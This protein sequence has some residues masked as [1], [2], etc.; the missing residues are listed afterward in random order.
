MNKFTF[1]DTMEKALRELQVE[2]VRD[3]LAEYEEHFAFK[4]ADGYSEEEIAAK[5]GGPR[6]LAKQFAAD[7]LPG[8]KRGS[9][10]LTA[11][12]LGFADIFTGSF[13]IALFGFVLVILGT[14]VAS[15]TIGVC[16][17][18]NLSGFGLLPPVPYGCALLFAAAF[19][20]FAILMGVGTVYFYVSTRQLL[21]SYCRWHQNA[22]ASAKGG[23]VYPPLSTHPQMGPRFNRRLRSVTLIA[24]TAFAVAFVLAYVVSAIVAGGFGFWHIWGWFVQ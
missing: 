8:R 1:M 23:A 18:L 20:A 13:F 2:D 12:G 24:L 15:A 5:L 10:A 6:A 17:A 3:I 19:L 11:L 16:L 14:A 4:M 7:S 22:F 9:A 21:R